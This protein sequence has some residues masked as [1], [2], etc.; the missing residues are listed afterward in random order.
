MASKVLVLFAFNMAI[1]G[2]GINRVYANKS[3]FKLEF[4]QVVYF[5]CLKCI[6]H[7]VQISCSTVYLLTVILLRTRLVYELIANEVHNIE[8]AI[9]QKRQE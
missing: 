5:E 3:I 6:T 9:S 7:H 4:I 2:K 1:Q 8:L